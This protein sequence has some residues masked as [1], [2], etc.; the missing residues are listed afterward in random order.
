[1]EGLKIVYLSPGE[2]RPYEKNPRINDN[3]VE[4]LI[5]SIMEYGFKVP[6]IVDKDKQIIAGHT[7]LKAALKMGLE[8]V[9]CIVADDLTDEQAQAFR[10]ADNKVSDFSIWDNRL[11]LE[12]LEA[13]QDSDLFTGF[14][15]DNISSL[16]V[17]NEKD[18]DVID[19]N[20]EGVTYEAVFRSMNKDKI[21]RIKEMWDAMEDE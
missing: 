6:I 21:D 11:L 1:M 3:A 10:I 7:R 20:E 2:L 17:L 13:L 5:K 18:N 8:T 9:P 14:D 15:F 16:D 19:E 12:E 4:P